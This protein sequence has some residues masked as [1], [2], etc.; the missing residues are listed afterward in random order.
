M[1]VNDFRLDEK[2]T[3]FGEEKVPDSKGGYCYEAS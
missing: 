2:G 3:L 1:I